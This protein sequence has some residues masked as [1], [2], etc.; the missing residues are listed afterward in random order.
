MHDPARNAYIIML[1]LLAIGAVMTLYLIRDRRKNPDWPMQRYIG[2]DGKEY[3]W[4]PPSR[5]Q[6]AG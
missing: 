4:L 5:D 1:V 3:I 6:C 2:A